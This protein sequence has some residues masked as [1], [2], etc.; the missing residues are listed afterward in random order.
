MGGLR[1][2]Y[3]NKY[4]RTDFHE[5][6]Q[7]WMI[8]MLYDMINQVDNFV[9][10]N[11]V[12][13]ADPIQWNITRQYEKNTI[14]VDA[15][16]GT[17]YISSKPVPMGVALSR[18]EYWSV[19]FDLGRFITLASQ[20][21]A[22]SYES[23]LTTTATMATDK[24]GWIVWNS[25]L[26]RAMNDIH[27]GDM[28]VVDGNIERYTVEMFFDE[29]VHLISEETE[30]RIEG[31][32]ALHDEIV[33]ESVARENA[34][35]TLQDNIDAEATAR[36][37]ADDVLQDNIDAEA[38]ARE[39]AD[40]T[41]G[42]RIDDEIT[43]REN[44]DT[45]LQ[46]NIDA[47]ASTRSTDIN[48][49]NTYEAIFVNVK[50]FGAVGNGVH[51]DT[52]AIQSAVNSISGKSI[53]YFPAGTYYITSPITMTGTS[54]IMGSGRMKTTILTA[55]NTAFEFRNCNGIDIHSMSIKCNTQGS[56][57]SYAIALLDG[58]LRV[59][60]HDMFFMYNYCD[61]YMSAGITEVVIDSI[62]AFNWTRSSVLIGDTGYCG[63]I[64]VVNSFFKCE[65][66]IVTNGSIEIKYCDV[67]SITSNTFITP[68]SN[69]VLIEPL[70][71][72]VVS[73]VSFV[74]NCFDTSENGI[75]MRGAG[76]ITRIIVTS[77]I[78]QELGNSGIITANA[79]T[80][81]LI[82]DDNAVFNV[83]VGFNIDSGAN[84]DDLSISN[85]NIV[86]TALGIRL[87]GATQ[88]FKC[89]ENI[90]GTSKYG[91]TLGTGI[92]AGSD[93]VKGVAF[94]NIFNNVTTDVSNASSNFTVY[95]YS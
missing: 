93:V 51:D 61:V 73:L 53:L 7:D 13:Y 6:N 18:T 47:E 4:P 20:N 68:F 46:D 9:E 77:N 71:N 84:I 5:L 35:T 44:A 39:D 22:N 82:I 2:W 76:T 15:I 90:F 56:A 65:H 58:T 81:Y 95:N 24:D 36:E 92:A 91:L 41:L 64:N 54:V 10:M 32:A 11:A 1:K 60:I 72:F 94:G 83:P 31:D 38:T 86:C 19:I 79:D 14:V 26:Y 23:V 63:S 16:T 33:D 42:G 43:A 40:D 34:D 30:S 29:L 49:I 78:F 59:N 66:N 17:A 57:G 27:V 69:S 87:V 37:D 45:T 50:K 70:Q 28:Y 48:L 25:L 74:S 8:S 62:T 85:N 12:K 21:F 67:S 3:M 80:S 88:G 52:S 55:D 75:L 89:N